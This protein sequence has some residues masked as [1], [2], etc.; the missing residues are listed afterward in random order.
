MWL[1]PYNEGMNKKC[2][3][4]GGCCAVFFGYNTSCISDWKRKIIYECGFQFA[5]NSF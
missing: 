1:L 3:K 4:V 2:V 5:A